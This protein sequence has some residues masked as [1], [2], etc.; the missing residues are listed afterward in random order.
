MY[1]TS[2]P[3][4]PT[5]EGKS[6]VISG[7]KF[8]RKLKKSKPKNV[9]TTG[10][11]SQEKLLGGSR[12][13]HDSHGTEQGPKIGLYRTKSTSSTSVK[14]GRKIFTKTTTKNINVDGNV[15]SYQT[16]YTK[17]KVKKNKS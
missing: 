3:L 6:K 1:R 17:K 2:K 15:S 10:S 4:H 7:K 14:K 12:R 11:S 5:E 13:N 9:T 8:N 16:T